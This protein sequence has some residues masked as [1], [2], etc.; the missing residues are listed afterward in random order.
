MPAEYL[1][2]RA[3]FTAVLPGIIKTGSLVVS[4]GGGRR[5]FLHNKPEFSKPISAKLDFA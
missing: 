2:C 5:I 1:Q 3:D 4:V